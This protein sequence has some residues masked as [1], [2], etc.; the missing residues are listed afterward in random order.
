MVKT[1]PQHWTIPLLE[2]GDKLSLYE[3]ERRYNAM[4]NLKKADW[5]ALRY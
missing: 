4:P 1:L 3:F 5:D 2:N